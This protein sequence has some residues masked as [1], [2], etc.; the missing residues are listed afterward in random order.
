ML[1]SL[2]AH[3]HADP[4]KNGYLSTEDRAYIEMDPNKK[5]KKGRESKKELFRLLGMVREEGE[6]SKDHFIRAN[7][8]LVVSI[9]KD[10][11]EM[12]FLIWI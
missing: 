4:A 8:R 11:S 7:L 9:A 2:T 6:Q 1:D 10:T 12:I 5:L 3:E